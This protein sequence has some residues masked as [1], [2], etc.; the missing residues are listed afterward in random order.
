MMKLHHTITSTAL[1]NTSFLHQ[2]ITFIVLLLPKD[3]GQPK[4]HRLRIINTYD[5]EYNLIL[6]YVWSKKGMQKSEKNKWLGDN[7]TGGRKGMNTIE[8]STLN[9]LI[10]ESR[11]VTK[12]PLCTHQDDAIG[13]YDRIIR[14]Y[15][16]INSRK[17]EIP[18]DVCKLHLKAHDNM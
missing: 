5:L 16:T 8:T 4:I 3:K 10:I 1:L 15:G 7:A 17:F 12:Q 14:T 11:R 18:D 6:K 2:W 9:E 13:R